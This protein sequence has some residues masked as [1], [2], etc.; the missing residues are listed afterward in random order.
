V[1]L[2]LS[3]ESGGQWSLLREKGL[4]NLYL[5]IARQ[6]DA[7]VVIDEDIAWRVFTKGLGKEEARSKVTVAGDQALGLKVLDMVSII[8]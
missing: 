8:A 6:P 3:G 1:T 5:G 2:T 4:W 7:E